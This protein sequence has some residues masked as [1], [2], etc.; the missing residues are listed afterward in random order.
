MEFIDTE[1]KIKV[2]FPD[3]W[4]VLDDKDV[5]VDSLGMSIDEASSTDF[6]LIRDAEKVEDIEYLTF[7]SDPEQY[8]TESE[9][10]VGLEANLAIVRERGGETIARD[11]TTNDD[12][13]RLDRIIIKF[14]NPEDAQDEFLM[15]Q[16]YAYANKHLFVGA[17]EIGE[18][19]D[20]LDNILQSVIKSISVVAPSAAPA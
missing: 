15:A 8:P 4:K 19:G 14:N 20:E 7:A 10:S 5:F 13:I 11:S 16:Y 6:L 17:V 2:T 3:N 9:Y 1:L 18:E 12:G